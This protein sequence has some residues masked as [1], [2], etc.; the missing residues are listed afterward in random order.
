MKL[1][2]LTIRAAK[3]RAKPRKLSDGHGLYLLIHPNG[4]KYWRVK[5][6]FSGKEK[7]LAVGV[8]PIVGL[9]SARRRCQDA[10]VALADG[11]DPMAARKAKKA[12]GL[13]RA[14]NSF[15]IVAREWFARQSPNWAPS[16]SSKIIRRLE[17]DLFPWLGARPIAEIKAPELLQVLRRIEARGALETAHRAL[18]NSG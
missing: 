1:T 7:V 12:A 14:A 5:Y 4:G 10:R 2:N 9:A 8:Y 17:R 11:I 3:P 15:E 13:E 18:Q 16:H 6:R